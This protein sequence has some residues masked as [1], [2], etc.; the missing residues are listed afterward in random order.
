MPEMLPP[1]IATLLAS[2]VAI[3]PSPRFVLA[4]PAVVA[5][6]PPLAIPSRPPS[7]IVPDPVI[8]QQ[9]GSFKVA[10]PEA[11]RQDCTAE[12]AGPGCF[13]PPGARIDITFV[14]TS[15]AGAACPGLEDFGL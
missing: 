13:P 14:E 7:V 3:V 5:P 1:V 10:F 9:A 11:M 4:P 6:V 2:C 12:P 8:C 15:D